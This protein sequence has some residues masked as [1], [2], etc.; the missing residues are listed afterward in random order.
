MLHLADVRYSVRLLLRSPIFAL[1]SVL[2]LT[3]GIAATT[4]IFSVADALLLRPRAGVTEP[5]RLVDVGRGQAD[6]GGFDT[7][8]YPLF[9]AMR[10]RSTLVESMAATM[11]ETVP[12]GLGRDGSSERVN[13]SLVSA[14]YFG[15]LGTR[16][17]IGRLL[18]NDD[19]RVPGERPAIVLSHRFWV[20][21][22]GAASDIVGR[23]LR[24]NDMAYTVVGV[25]EEGFNGHTIVSPD[26]WV[27]ITMTPAV[28]GNPAGLDLLHSHAAA[29]HTAVAR[30]KPDVSITQARD[31]LDAI[32]AAVVGE[33]AEAYAGRRWRIAVEPSRRIPVPGVGP[34]RA[35]VG[36]LFALTSTV[37]LIAC[38]NVAAMLLVRGSA[39]RRELATRLAMGADRR[40]LVAQLLAE[41]VVVFLTA[42]FA[43]ILLTSW[44][45]R[46]LEA[47]IPALPVPIALD[48]RADPRAFGFALAASLTTALTFGLAPARHALSIDVASALHGQHATIDRRRLTLRHA[49]VVGQLALSLLLLVTTALF[50]RSSR[51]AA[52]IDP[53]FD[54]RSVDVLTLDTKLANLRG[55]D[56]VRVVDDVIE[57]VRALDGVESVAVSRMTP[58]R[59]S[60]MSLGRLRVPGTQSPSGSDDWSSDWDLVS[61]DYF[62]TLRL[63]IVQGRVFTA[64]DRDGAPLVAI[65]NETFARRVWP[66]RSAVGQRVWQVRSRDRGEDRAIEIVGVARDAKYRS[67]TE[68]PRAFIYVP[69]AQHPL[70]EVSLYV[71]HANNRSLAADLRAIVRDVESRLPVLAIESLEGAIGVGL[72]PQRVAAWVAGSVGV[73]GLLLASLGLYGVTAFAVAQRTREIAVRMAI[74]ASREAVLRMTLA[75]GARLAVAGA[76]VGL[77]LAAGAG[78][79]VR[80]LLIGVHPIDPVAFL[81]AAGVLTAAVLVATWIPARR[82]ADLDPMVA[83]RAE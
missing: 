40:R 30:L 37:L 49:L 54:P 32:L 53:G 80:S 29:W 71:R 51:A 47:F 23:P 10:E 70:P 52:G 19:D 11:V 41:T 20:D 78:L 42:G 6:G 81:T 1:T 76:L 72:L 14:G 59:G 56:A 74:G 82:A 33:Q 38:S 34:A 8:G 79:L 17:A 22:F 39:R 77:L 18:V 35:F 45:L 15:V 69:F 4:A 83:L 67:V 68:S 31:E 50:V 43:S 61:P 66:D 60:G 75:Q 64:G 46:A 5:E 55:Q 24:L 25:A 48:L 62:T 2:S 36:L 73:L 63:P 27:P 3:A 16:P 7:F 9:L 13:A 65:V 26:F 57:R 21:R 44:L 12:M 58:L 28:R